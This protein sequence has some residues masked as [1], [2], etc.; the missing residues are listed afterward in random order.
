MQAVTSEEMV[1][2]GV[3]SHL[4]E[5]GIAGKGGRGRASGRKDEKVFQHGGKNE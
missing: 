4:A 1:L 2:N 5:T 3:E